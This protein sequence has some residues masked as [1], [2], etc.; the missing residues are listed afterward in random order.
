MK[1]CANQVELFEC[2]GFTVPK[3]TLQHLAMLMRKARQERNQRRRRDSIPDLTGLDMTQPMLVDVVYGIEMDWDANPNSSVR[4][5]RV[6][7]QGIFKH[8]PDT[9]TCAEAK[10]TEFEEPPSIEWIARVS[11][12]MLYSALHSLMNE[13][14]GS[15]SEIKVA[16]IEWLFAKTLKA[17]DV[18]RP[19][20]M[21]KIPFT[22][23]FC[24]Y[25]EEVDYEDL[26]EVIH[27]LVDDMRA[28]QSASQRTTNIPSE[29]RS[30]GHANQSQ[31]QS[32]QI[33]FC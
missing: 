10:I 21:Y 32:N 23:Q 14:T 1:T 26:C 8:I 31:N 30:Y 18:S 25:V 17:G 24:C 28:R 20:P 16:L 4:K 27:I 12:Y 11:A 29:E 3:A 5:E 22:A 33:S 7:V 13:N 6:V 15:D 2:G 9:G 19:A